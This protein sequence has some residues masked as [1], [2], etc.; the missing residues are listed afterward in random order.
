MHL[1]HVYGPDMRLRCILDSA[2]VSYELKNNDLSVASF[3]LPVEDPKGALIQAHDYVRIQD[4]G[5]EIGLFRV[6]SWEGSLIPEAGVFTTYQCEHVIATLLDSVMDG[7][8]I[9]GSGDCRTADVI[10]YILSFQDTQRWVLDACDFDDAFEYVFS[11][12]DCLTA[13]MSLGKVLLERYRWIYDTSELPWRISLKKAPVKPSCGLNYRRNLGDIVC[14]VDATRLIT[15]LYPK[16]NGEGI[17]QLTIAD[18]NGGVVYLD[19]DAATIASYGV[20]AGVYAAPD[21]E[22]PALLMAKGRQILNQLSRPVYSYTVT[23]L[24]N[25]QQTG[26]HWDRFATGDLVRVYDADHGLDLTTGIELISKADVF[27]DPAVV[28]LTLSTASAD[29]VGDI[30]SLA[31]RVAINELY[32]QG[33]TQMYPLQLADN[34]DAEHPLVM[35]YYVPPEA[36]HINKV[37]LSWQVENFRAYSK[38]AAAGG[39][40]TTTTEFGGSTT[41]VQEQILI[42]PTFSTGIPQNPS[43]GDSVTFTGAASPETDEAGAHSHTG[44]SH[45]HSF[46]GNQDLGWGNVHLPGAAATGGNTGGVYEYEKKQIVISGNTGY[47]GTGETEQA[48]GHS[49]TVAEHT[50]YM[51]HIHL[52]QAQITVPAQDIVI[53]SH[54]HSVKYPG[55][56]HG[57]SY[58]IYEGSR[59]QG[60][61]IKVDDTELPAALLDGS[62]VD[63]AAYMA[64]DPD[65]KIQ[66]DSWH[67][68]EIVPDSLTRII[69]NLY[70]QIFIQHRGGGNY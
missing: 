10:R 6:I 9:I 36:R 60:V 45:R 2:A 12:Q 56:S 17:N 50:H 32:S 20:K 3:Q 18:V 66:R 42:T 51:G 58:G 30:N 22:D 28:T 62:Q 59:A 63:V 43:T 19:A 35:R 13:L 61:T 65:G 14:T 15:R 21:I 25:Y 70:M 57:I 68:I 37:I 23:A 64:K 4:G 55:H 53:P 54:T 26:L 5:V 38:G 8:H 24:D 49:H 11:N 67:V 31:D 52:G 41:V 16:G 7:D 27:G 29:L 1:L 33:T 39:G 46:T 40:T 44:P 48:G 69:G 47:A 34:A